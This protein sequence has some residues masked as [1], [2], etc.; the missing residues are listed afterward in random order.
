MCMSVCVCV[1]ACVCQC[2][3]VRERMCDCVC[4]CESVCVRVSACVCSHTKN[5]MEAKISCK[6]EES[7]HLWSSIVN[8]NSV[9]DVLA[10]ETLF[11]YTVRYRTI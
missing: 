7:V 6:V 5:K 4:M 3:C 9:L 8:L 1:C 11:G 10:F 2:V